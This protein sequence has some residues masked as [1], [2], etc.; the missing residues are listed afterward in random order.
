MAELKDIVDAA[1]E[2]YTLTA[3]ELDKYSDV[4]HKEPKTPTEN[5]KQCSSNKFSYSSSS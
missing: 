2:V 4:A 1:T 3:S 5:R